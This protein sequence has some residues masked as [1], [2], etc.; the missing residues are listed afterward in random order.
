MLL[1]RTQTLA[2]NIHFYDCTKPPHLTLVQLPLPPHL[3]HDS[4]NIS[5]EPFM[6]AYQSDQEGI[7]FSSDQSIPSFHLIRQSLSVKH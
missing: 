2:L 1:M 3:E 4:S 6:I 5:P 7:L